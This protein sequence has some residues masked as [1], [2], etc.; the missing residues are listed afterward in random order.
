MVIGLA[1]LAGRLGLPGDAP[2]VLS[3]RGSLIVR[4]G[5]VAARVSTVTASSRREPFAWLVR[6]VAMGSYAG[7]RGAPVVPP[8]PGV[9]PGPY[10]QDGFAISLW[11]YLTRCS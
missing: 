8:P 2:V 6:E 5:A 4:L 7:G 3:N 9:P 10:Q 1:A 11:R